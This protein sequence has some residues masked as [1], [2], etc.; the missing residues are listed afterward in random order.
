MYEEPNTIE[1]LLSGLQDVKY[2]RS[3]YCPQAVEQAWGQL[4]WCRMYG[5][6]LYHDV[7]CSSAVIR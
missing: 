7:T 1:Q 5:L 4:R 3:V 2:L 6:C